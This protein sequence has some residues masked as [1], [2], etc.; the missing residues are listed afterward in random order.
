MK[1]SESDVE[2]MGIVWVDFYADVHITYSIKL[3]YISHYI[4][5]V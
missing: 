5:N 1:D 2:A 3:L 4:H